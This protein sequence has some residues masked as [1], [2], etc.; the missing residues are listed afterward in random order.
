MFVNEL[1]QSFRLNNGI[2]TSYNDKIYS[3]NDLFEL[4]FSAINI[5]ETN[6]IREGS[7]VALIGD[8]TPNSISM[9]LALLY[10]KCTVIPLDKNDDISKKLVIAQCEF[11][12]DSTYFHKY[13]ISITKNKP[14]NSLYVILKERSSSGLVIFTS[15]TSGNPK[16]ALHDFNNIASSYKIT[17]NTSQQDLILN[18]L[19]FDHW[20]GLNTLFRSLCASSKVVYLGE[21]TPAKVCEVIQRE[22]VTVLPTTPTFLNLLIVSGEYK[23]WNLSSLR[24]ITYGAEPI[25]ESTL[26]KISEIFP[27]IRLKQ[28]YGLIE[29]GVVPTKSLSNNSLLVKLGGDNFQYRIID[30]ILQ[31]K[32]PTTILGYLNALAPI[33][34][35]G[36][37]ITGDKV[38][39]CGEYLHI[40]GRESELINIGGEKFYPI[41]VEDVIMNYSSDIKDA[42]VYPEKNS[43]FGS[44]LSAKITVLNNFEKEQYPRLK[45]G[46]TNH[47]KSN[48]SKHKIPIKFYFS[49]D[50]LHGLR[51][52]KNRS[53]T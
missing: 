28:T 23:R 33:T 9:L 44:I 21:R 7:I 39:V 15:G 32:S 29:L 38:K 24:L 4:I 47:C 5:C 49:K 16:G 20:G 42:L 35:D 13:D 2:F 41:E 25:G 17:K 6:Y 51:F 11:I 31:I 22:S 26:Q 27:T 14:D 40:L 43:L 52:K 53:N 10:K 30:D 46:I 48:L 19:L 3:Y 45:E 37:F 18:F 36:W 50:E 12:I 8:F 1:L 34:E